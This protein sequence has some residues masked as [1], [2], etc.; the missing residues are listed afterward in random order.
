MRGQEERQWHNI[1]HNE[2][3]RIPR[4]H[5][6]IDTESRPRKTKTGSVQ[7]WRLGVAW[8]REGRKGSPYRDRWA[9]YETPRAMWSDITKYCGDKGRTVLWAHNLGYDVR[10]GE[11]FKHLPVLGWRITGHNIAPRGTWL[12]WRRGNATLCMADSTSVFATSIA[13]LGA[14]FGIGKVAIEMDSEDKPR[15]LER[16]R[17]DVRILGTA[18][19]EYM[20]WLESDDMGNWQLTGSSQ[21]WAAFRHKFLTHKLTVHDDERA[22]AA[23]RRA[24]W[25]GRC[26]AYWHGELKSEQVYEFDFAN[27]YPRIARDYTVPVK[28]LGPMPRGYDWRKVAGSKHSAMLCHVHVKTS[29]PVVPT[30]NDGRILW[31]VGEFDTTLWDVEILAAIKA[32]ATITVQEGWIYRKAPALKAWAEWILAQLKR[33]DS[34]VP[35]WQKSILKHWS[36]ALIGRLAMTYSQWEDYAQAPTNDVMRARM[37]DSSTGKEC[38]IMQIGG[39]IFRDCGRAE[40]THSMPMITGYVQAIARTQLWD[41]L[42]MVPERTAIYA[43]TDSILCT[44]TG[45]AAM[46]KAASEYTAA[47]LRLKRVWR[48]FAVYGPRQIVTGER[49]RVSGIPIRSVQVDKRT[50]RGEIWDTLPGALRKGALDTVVTRDREWTINGTDHR[51]EGN[52]FGWTQ[53]FRAGPTQGRVGIDRMGDAKRASGSAGR[54]QRHTDPADRTPE[55]ADARSGAPHGQAPKHGR[56]ARE[57]TPAQQAA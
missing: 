3:T 22:L 33:P 8:F 15:W 17:V 47:D 30:L 42:S 53:P 6:F 24:M 14:M 5:V 28:L 26:E 1:R 12:E 32:G 56:R 39:A 43:D 36:R 54:E 7:K 44:E 27:S 16:C 10:I 49:V 2:T 48:G 11:A 41:I 37:Y 50:F 40:W 51:R 57:V 55:A 45:L 13:K 38:E 35:A 21:S 23:E 34:D 18:M 9:N 46:E 25:T 19:C 29:A 52:G 31:P 20:A 4:K